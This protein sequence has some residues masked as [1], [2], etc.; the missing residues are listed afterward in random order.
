[1]RGDVL[2]SA[3]KMSQQC[4]QHKQI[5]FNTFSESLGTTCC[6]WVIIIIIR[7]AR[8]VTLICQADELNSPLH[9]WLHLHYISPVSEHLYSDVYLISRLLF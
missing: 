2:S 9:V 7:F 6:E 4:D 1:M 3:F 8:A 5:R